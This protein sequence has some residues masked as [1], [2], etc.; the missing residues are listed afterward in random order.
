MKFLHIADLHIGKVLNQKSLL[1]DQVYILNQIINQLEET[2]ASVLVLAGDVYDRSV[3]SKEAVAIFNDFLSEVILN[4]KKKV[5]IITGNHDSQERLSFTSGILKKHG[6][7]IVAYPSLPLEDIVLED[8][9]GKV[10]FYALP[11]STPFS[12]KHDFGFDC[13]T[14]EDM[15]RTFLNA[16]KLNPNERNVLI[17]HHT[18]LHEGMVETSDSESDISIGGIPGVEGKVLSGFDYVCLGH[19]HIPQSI[20]SEFIRYSGS[21]LKYSEQEA[22]LDKSSVLVTLNEKGNKK[23]D[24][25]KLNPLKNLRILTG[26]MEDLLR[27]EDSNNLDYV[28]IKLEDTVLVPD[29]M[30]RIRVKYPNALGLRYI[31]LDTVNTVSSISKDFHTKNLNNQF[32]EF[33]ELVMGTKITEEQLALL[34]DSKGD[35]L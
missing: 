32:A 13:E 14:Y 21:I 20:G 4:K 12:A 16:T 28:Y 31:K 24:L 1:D 8:E 34:E 26:L 19:I 15:I 23:I 5:I 22:Q 27:K 10:H 7:Y 3:P 29:A 11:F 2:N 30:R 33:Y 25:L 9:Y 6:L 35:T 18:I 17:T